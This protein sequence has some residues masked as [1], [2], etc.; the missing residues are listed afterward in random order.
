MVI[1]SKLDVDDSFYRRLQTMKT[2]LVVSLMR[3]PA[4]L[5]CWCLRQMKFHAGI[6]LGQLNFVVINSVANLGEASGPL[7]LGTRE[8]ALKNI[9]ENKISNSYK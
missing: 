9:Q 6:L 1:S 8:T 7:V 4:M 2:C 3:W 5:Q